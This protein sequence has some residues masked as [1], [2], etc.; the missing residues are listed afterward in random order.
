MTH[1]VPEY[2]YVLEGDLTVQFAD[3]SEKTFHQGDILLQP[4][5]AWHRGRN[6]G[7]RPLRF[8]AVSMGAKGV[9]GI[10]H[11]PVGPLAQNEA[12]ASHHAEHQ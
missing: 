2:L 1:P 7:Q 4:R 5:A 3:G 10:L 9:P 11:P 8:L 6:E 12:S